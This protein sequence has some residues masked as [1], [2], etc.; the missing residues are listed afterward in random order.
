MAQLS[1]SNW[2]REVSEDTIMQFLGQPVPRLPMRELDFPQ[3]GDPLVDDESSD[4]GE[5]GSDGAGDEDEGEGEDEEDGDVGDDEVWDH[6]EEHS[7]EILDE[8]EAGKGSM[9]EN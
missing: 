1:G 4:D 6:M 7:E 3:V 9:D 5:E 8:R 2:G